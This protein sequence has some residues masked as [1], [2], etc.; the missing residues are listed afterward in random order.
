M[1]ASEVIQ[2]LIRAHMAGDED[3]FRTIALQLAATEARAGHRLVAGRIRDIVSGAVGDRQPATGPTPI[4][5]PSRDLRN[6]LAV[7]Y[8]KERLGDIVL[9]EP[10]ALVLSRVLREHRSSEQLKEWGLSPRRKL[11]FFGPPGCGK[12]LAAAVLAG[13]LGLPLLRV[14]VETLFSRFLGE[15]AAL[16]TEIFDE[17]RRVRGIYLFD[18]FDAIGRQR[19]DVNDIGEAKRIV[20]TFLQLLDNDESDSL[21]VAATNEVDALDAALFRRFDDVAPFPLPD[22]KALIEL[23]RLRTTGHKFSRVQIDGLAELAE[24][25]SAADVTRAVQDALKS[26]VLDERRRLTSDDVAAPIREMLHRGQP[27]S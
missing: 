26:M 7:S 14:R 11:L 8:P 16:L 15:T 13:E 25:L 24:G 6:V 2:E 27:S 1:A 20:S 18:E 10:S 5:R 22:R 12:T 17:M 9:V 4:A 19:A 21:V 3:R 23:L